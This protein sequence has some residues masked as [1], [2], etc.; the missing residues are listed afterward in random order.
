[1][2][3]RLDSR[4]PGFAAEFSAFLLGKRETAVDVDEAV[5]AII[6]DVHV[7]GDAALIELTRKFDR[8]ALTPA[9]LRISAAEIDAAERACA[10]DT[11]AAL[12]FAARRIE[13]YHRRQ[14]PRDEL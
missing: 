10:S 7:R 1:M 11:L 13:A 9:T 8:V 3:R 4:V 14:V 5:A 2:P 12:E 6:A